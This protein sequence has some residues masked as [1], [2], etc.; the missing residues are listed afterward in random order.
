[1]KH[2]CVFLIFLFFF[3][4]YGFSQDP[5]SPK[6]RVEGDTQIKFG[7][8]RL[9][10]VKDTPPASPQLG[11]LYFD[12]TYLYT[13]DG[14]SWT[15]VSQEGS[16]FFN[17]ADN[18]IY[19]YDGTQWQKLGGGEGPKTVATRIVAASDSPDK[20]RA[21]YICD[22]TDDQEEINQAIIDV[23]FN[24]N[25]PGLGGSVYLLAG[26]YNISDNIAITYTKPDGT[27][28]TYSTPG[29][30][31]YSNISLIGEGAGTV[32]KAVSSTNYDIINVIGSSTTPLKG[33]FISQL[34][35]DGNKT[36]VSGTHNGV[37]F[38]YVQNSK[39]T[40]VWIENCSGSAI[41]LENSSY[42]IFSKSFLLNCSKGIYFDSSSNNII[43]KNII[44]D[45]T[46]GAIYF[47]STS[48]SN[49]NIIES[50][51]ICNLTGTVTTGAVRLHGNYNI[52]LANHITSSKIGGVLIEGDYNLLY[53]NLLNGLENFGVN[54]SSS[55]YNLLSSNHIHL[56]SSNSA[57]GIKIE[58]SSDSNLLV[59]N[60]IWDQEDDFVSLSILDSDKLLIAS[61]YIL[62]PGTPDYGI[63]IDSFSKDNYITGNQIIDSST[64]SPGNIKDN[65]T[66]TQYTQKEKMTIE[67]YTFP[68]SSISS[69]YKLDTF[70][71][72][73]AHSYIAFNINRAGTY[74]VYLTTGKSPGDILIL[75]NK[76]SNKN[77]FIRIYDYTDS[78]SPSGNVIN[79]SASYIDL[80]KNDILKLIWNGTHWIELEHIDN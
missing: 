7:T 53:S 10:P 48:D 69:P 14:S 51:I 26:T 70:V 32:L 71:N 54:L 29:V 65:G 75:E 66:N 38:N 20:N 15:Q 3:F 5:I 18:S 49:Y 43:A 22:G 74:T 11:D 62:Y 76:T 80:G 68:Y 52:F 72:T 44:E 35:V 77:N 27:T 41:K 50:N 39:I 59:G 33:A 16:L 31:L 36:N 1:M 28:L 4:K 79:L 13:W 34:R 9:K 64:N 55:T 23:Y 24:Q 61:N 46:E 8:L 60:Y 6:I 73:R 47:V 2:K 25:N 63:E 67:K 42:N 57:Y 37:H 58:S 56:G 30:V 21:H 78:G 17:D 12:G 45:I 40:K 19:F